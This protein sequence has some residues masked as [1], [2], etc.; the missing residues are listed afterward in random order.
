V[1]PRRSLRAGHEC[2]CPRPLRE[3]EKLRSKK[4]ATLSQ[5]LNIR[6][7]SALDRRLHIGSSSAREV[8]AG[9]TVG[10]GPVRAADWTFTSG[11]LTATIGGSTDLQRGRR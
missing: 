3:R 1:L 7:R 6:L 9:A 4:I 10:E 11:R 2:I 8:V 5:Y